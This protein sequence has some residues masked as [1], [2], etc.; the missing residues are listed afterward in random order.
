MEIISVGFVSDFVYL[1]GG[2]HL[3]FI[4]GGMLLIWVVLGGFWVILGLLWGH[5]EGELG[6]CAHPPPPPPPHHPPQRDLGS[7]RAPPKGRLPPP[8]TMNGAYN[9]AAPSA[10]H[11]QYGGSHWGSAQ[12][13]GSRRGAP[14]TRL[15]RVSPAPF[16]GAPQ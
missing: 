14:I 4:G 13:G 5:L 6:I 11:A 10:V 15:Y 16:S 8:Q 9:M 12:H 2:I 1:G 3:S 7:R